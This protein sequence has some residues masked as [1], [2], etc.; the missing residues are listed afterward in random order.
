MFTVQPTAAAQVILYNIRAFLSGTATIP[1]PDQFLTVEEQLLK[2]IY[3]ALSGGGTTPTLQQ[4]LGAGND[5]GG[6][7]IMNVDSAGALNNVPI[8]SQAG[9]IYCAKL[10]QSGTNDPVVT[11]GNYDPLSIG[12]GWTRSA[13]GEYKLAYDP[14]LTFKGQFNVSMIT[15]GGTTKTMILKV[16]AVAHELQITTFNAGA[17]AD[18]IL[19]DTYVFFTT[20]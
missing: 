4:V 12:T 18:G 13:V 8:L 3:D 16:D 9:W 15:A 6:I 5:G 14:G 17:N 20:L 1:M 11:I 2:D 7:E 19:N 10:T